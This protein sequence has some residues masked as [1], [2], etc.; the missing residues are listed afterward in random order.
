LPQTLILLAVGAILGVYCRYFA[1]HLSS[2]LSHHHGFPY[3]TLAVN[4]VASLILGFVLS[5]VATRVSDDRWRLFL[6]TG[7]CGTLSTFSTFAFECA[8]YLKDGRPGFFLLNLALNN[9]LSMAAIFAGA[10]LAAFRVG[11]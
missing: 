8:V 1:T 2:R 3:G 6:A 5:W 9:A 7:F 10:Y 11:A 4:V